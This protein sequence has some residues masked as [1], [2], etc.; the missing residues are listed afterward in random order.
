MMK[1][2]RPITLMAVKSEVKTQYIDILRPLV[3]C[4]PLLSLTYQLPHILRNTI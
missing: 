1:Y 4:V 3:L 2:Y